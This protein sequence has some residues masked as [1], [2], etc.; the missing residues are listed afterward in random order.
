MATPGLSTPFLPRVNEQWEAAGFAP[1]PPR[2]FVAAAGEAE[3]L[4]ARFLQ[5]RQSSGGWSDF[6]CYCL[7]TNLPVPKPGVV[8]GELFAINDS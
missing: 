7:S 8:Q 2:G 4:P 5:A 3:E 1:A 6:Y